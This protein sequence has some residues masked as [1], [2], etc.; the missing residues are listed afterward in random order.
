M[1][2]VFAHVLSMVYISADNMHAN[3]EMKSIQFA[4]ILAAILNTT[5]NCE[6]TVRRYSS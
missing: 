4:A 1:H 6:F 3:T 5:P 2:L